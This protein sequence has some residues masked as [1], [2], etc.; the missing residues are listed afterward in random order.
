MGES[1]TESTTISLTETKMLV[2]RLIILIKFNNKH[3]FQKCNEFHHQLQ[4]KY[5]E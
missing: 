2:P 1:K 5:Q 4:L 3:N